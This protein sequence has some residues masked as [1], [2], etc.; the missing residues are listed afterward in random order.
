MNFYEVLAKTECTKHIYFIEKS[1]Q[2]VVLRLTKK[3]EN[4]HYKKVFVGRLSTDL[5]RTDLMDYFSQ[6]GIITDITIPQPF[7][8]FAFITFQESSKLIVLIQIN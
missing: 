8:S 6:F 3:G 4:C 7:R 5:N 1:K 2:K